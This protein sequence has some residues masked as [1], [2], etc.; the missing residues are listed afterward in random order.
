MAITKFQPEIWSPAILE[1]MRNKLIY[2]QAGLINRDYEGDVSKWGDT[3]HITDFADPS[4]RSYT[5]NTNIT[6]DLLTDAERTLLIDQS[7]YFAFTVDDIDKRQAMGGFIEKTSAGAAYNLAADADSFV[8][9]LMVSAVNGTANDLGA[10]TVDIS[11]NDA[12]GLLFVALRTVLTRDKVPTE[13]RWVVVPPEIYA[14]LLQD[15]RFTD[16][17]AS[18]DSGQALR[19]GFVGRVAGF[20]VFESNLVPEP[21]SGVYHVLAG[22]PM[23]T[24]FADQINSVEALRLEN[25]F[26]DG[27]RGLHLYGGKVIRP[28]CLAL[29]SVTVQA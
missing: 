12:Y 8:S 16:A 10:I 7:D 28:T 9:G 19:N 2:G 26:G 29:A 6:W 24:T 21:T 5:K 22:H 27:I 18:A 14:A 13:G 17:S 23:A 4:V 11:S 20:D 3:V 15:P 25:Q 1:N